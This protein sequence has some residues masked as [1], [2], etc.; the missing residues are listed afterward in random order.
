MLDGTYHSQWVPFDRNYL[1]ITD[2]KKIDS[3]NSTLALQSERFVFSSDGSFSAIEKLKQ[4]DPDIFKRGHS[5]M[6]WG[7]KTY[8]PNQEYSAN[9]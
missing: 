7:R 5:H 2:S 9:D 8:Y 3:Y 1:E 6:L 4:E